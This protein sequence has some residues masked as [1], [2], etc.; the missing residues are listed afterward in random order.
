ML[1]FGIRKKLH[2]MLIQ[3]ENMNHHQTR[4]QADVLYSDL[5]N[6]ILMLY[7][8]FC[9]GSRQWYRLQLEAWNNPQTEDSMNWMK[10]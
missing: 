2:E 6:L 7:R 10:N 5:F 9:H 4:I 3:R 8:G 1:A